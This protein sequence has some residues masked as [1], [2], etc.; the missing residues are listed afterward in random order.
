MALFIQPVI[1]DTGSN[2]LF[3]LRKSYNA[4]LDALVAAADFPT[5]QANLILKAT[6]TPKILLTREVPS[7][8]EFPEHT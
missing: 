6:N 7:A 2:E 3:C 4:L 5:L 1:G 8:R